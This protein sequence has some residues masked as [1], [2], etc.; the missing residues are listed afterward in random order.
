[1]TKNTTMLSI[2][3]VF[4]WGCGGPPAATAQTAPTRS[5]ERSSAGAATTPPREADASDIRCNDDPRAQP[6]GAL[7]LGHYSTA[8][9]STGFVL[10]RTGAEPRLSRDGHDEVLVLREKPADGGSEYV[11][12]GP[13]VWIRIE[14]HGHVMYQG[15]DGYRGVDAYRDANARPLSEGPPGPIT[16]PPGSSGQAEGKVR[17]GHYSVV[18]G[19]AGFVLDQTASPPRLKRD[20][21][22][23][24]VELESKPA[25]GRSL[26]ELVNDAADVWIRVD[27][28]AQLLYQ[29]PEH[30]Q[31]MRTVRDANAE[32][33]R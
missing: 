12:E 17:L 24:I 25:E 31:G 23:E 5:D 7:R 3:S 14:R 33:L 8:D 1:M 13:D 22:D 11:H 28:P 29:G 19:S 16:C 15:P 20:G 2:L 18:D 26:V 27:G 30:H 21:S 6:E 32:P 9:G 4:A 10:D